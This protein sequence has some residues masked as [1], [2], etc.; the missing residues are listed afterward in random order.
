MNPSKGISLSCDIECVQGYDNSLLLAKCCIIDT[1][2][3]VVLNITIKPDKPVKNYI[4][5]VTGL[6]RGDL[7]RGVECSE[8]KR[9][10]KTLFDTADTIVFHDCRNDLK[11][12]E[13]LPLGEVVDTS[14]HPGLIAKTYLKRASKERVGLKTMGK[15]LLGVH[16]QEGA[17]SAKEDAIVTMRL[18]LLIKSE[19]L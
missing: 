14:N 19:N 12:L 18:F 10:I 16:I 15:L 1:N 11:V 6:R 4:T 5:W 9:M 3:E 8:G 2:L 13:Y 17:H 7:N